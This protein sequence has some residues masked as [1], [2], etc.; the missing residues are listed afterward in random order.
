MNKIIIRLINYR[1]IVMFLFM[2]IQKIINRIIKY[3]LLGQMDQIMYHYML[4]INMKYHLQLVT[5]MINLI[6]Q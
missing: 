1:E 2:Q 5:V 6:I 3:A 4:V